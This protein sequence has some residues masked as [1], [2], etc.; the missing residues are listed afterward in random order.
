MPSPEFYNY[1]SKIKFSNSVNPTDDYEE[2]KAHDVASDD[3]VIVNPVY[4]HVKIIFP[5]GSDDYGKKEFV[6]EGLAF[7][8]E[9]KLLS[10]PKI[11]Y[12]ILVGFEFYKK[13]PSNAIK[14]NQSKFLG[15]ISQLKKKCK[16]YQ[17]YVFKKIR[18]T[19]ENFVLNLD[20]FQ[21]G[22]FDYFK[23]KTLIEKETQSDYHIRFLKD[24]NLN[25]EDAGGMFSFARREKELYIIDFY[26]LYE[27]KIIDYQTLLALN[28]LY[29]EAYTVKELEGFW[30]DF[31]EEQKVSVAYGAP[32]LDPMRFKYSQLDQGIQI[33]IYY[34]INNDYRGWVIPWHNYINKVNFNF[35]FDLDETS[36][37]NSRLYQSL[38]FTS[39]FS[40]ILNQLVNFLSKG[41]YEL[42]EQKFSEAVLNYWVGLD[43]ILNNTEEGNSNPLKNRVSALLWYSERSSHK[44]VYFKI[45]E[46]YTRR[47][48]YV[49]AGDPASESDA[50]FLRRA[51]QSI[52]DILIKVHKR[53]AKKKDLTYD[54]W[55]SDID[56]LANLGR[57]TADVPTE[58]LF[59]IGIIEE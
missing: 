51:C 52:L 23:V 15:F 47:S 57:N 24:F 54:S 19:S 36:K 26:F 1:L 50:I 10:S 58:L 31:E 27:N 16:V 2:I 21:I 11:F 45:N 59:K 30:N 38:K 42:G 35:Q 29:F 40:G 41:N 4:S 3:G 32:Y 28:D 34:R 9:N 56:E 20:S 44:S 55:I 14:N 18:N 22:K 43:T 17:V 13:H 48:K 46:S 49:H 6:E 53:V 39:D 12:S 37:L 8:S 25:E 7:L 33:T 5:L